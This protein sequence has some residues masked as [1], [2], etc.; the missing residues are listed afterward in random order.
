M[1]ARIA[2]VAV[3][4]ESQEAARKFWAEQVG[5][6]VR[7]NVPM[8]PNAFWLEM[9][10]PGAQSAL[11]IYPKT[12]K[13]DANEHK[14]DIVF[15]TQNFQET[16]DAMVAKGVKFLEEPQKMQWGTHARF[17]D[18]DGNQFLLKD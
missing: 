13:P 18:L 6:E 15:E 10:P 11:V 12:M 2:T 5:F 3:Y 17:E 4:V 9:A 1:I 8:G 14:A 7:R 16:Y